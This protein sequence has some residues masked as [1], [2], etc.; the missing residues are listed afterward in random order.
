MNNKYKIILSL[1][2]LTLLIGLLFRFNPDALNG[3]DNF[4]RLIY[5][6]IIA[7][8]ISSR[9]L[10]KSN[11]GFIL[12]NIAL[13]SLIIASIT[14]LHNNR[15]NFIN[16]KNNIISSFSPSQPI[17]AENKVILT[18]DLDGHFHVKGQID[19]K[20][21][22]FMIDTGASNI[23]LNRQAA[24]RIGINLKEL[25]FNQ[26]TKTANGTGSMA[27]IRLKKIAIGN[28]ILYDIPATVNSSNMD[29]SLLG[30]DFLNHLSSFSVSKD[31]LILVK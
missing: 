28:I 25:N 15:F 4:S 9:I 23:V 18:K 5:L 30:M 12:K 13:W 3:P 31:K 20:P 7:V 6:L 16:I 11:L 22:K 26:I 29:E 24:E 21:V 19:D 2:A 14:L 17:M 27:S 1:T 8:L 10:R